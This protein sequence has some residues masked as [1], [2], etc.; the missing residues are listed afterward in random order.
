MIDYNCSQCGEQMTSPDS[1]AGK[2]EQC[3]ACGAEVVVLEVTMPLPPADEQAF[4]GPNPLSVPATPPP[5][6]TTLPVPPI[7]LTP[8]HNAGVLSP[9]G[10][11]WQGLTREHT[12]EVIQKCTGMGRQ[13]AE[14][15]F[16]YPEKKLRAF[17]KSFDNEVP[18]GDP[19]FRLDPGEFPINTMISPVASNVFLI[20]N[21]CVYDAQTGTQKPLNEIVHT[22]MRGRSAMLFINGQEFCE[23]FLSWASNRK[24]YTSFIRTMS[25]VARQQ[26]P[27]LLSLEDQAVAVAVV[28][29]SDDFLDSQ[30]PSHRALMCDAQMD[31][32]YI[33]RVYESLL[34]IQSESMGVMGAVAEIVI[35]LLI[36][37]GGAIVTVLGS[38]L[39][40]GLG[41]LI[42]GL[43]LFTG[44]WVV[45]KGFMGL[46][47]GKRFGL[48]P[49]DLH[50]L[51]R[52][53]M[54]PA[55]MATVDVEN[56]ARP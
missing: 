7:S 17:A 20:T 1:L 30:W 8:S 55:D 19:T 56:G 13:A 46:F 41:F 36:M 5:L 52:L 29:A 37:A 4:D 21:K 54:M 35:G 45:F 22:E 10:S 44:G 32:D 31:G 50:T 9:A 16:C 23:T 33:D 40:D 24:G 6:P 3:S 25:E 48:N 39:L 2:S 51:W 26:C 18:K 49:I 14:K 43:G 27:T 38:M 12:L 28:V 42:I 53:N 34:K 47:K 11:A 15:K